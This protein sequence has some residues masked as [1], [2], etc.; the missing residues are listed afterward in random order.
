MKDHLV[1]CCFC[2]TLIGVLASKNVIDIPA[3]SDISTSSKVKFNGTIVRFNSYFRMYI[4]PW[5]LFCGMT[6]SYVMMTEM[7]TRSCIKTQLVMDMRIE[8]QVRLC[9]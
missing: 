1:L 9:S 5:V 8:F 2:F 4:T 6:R 3:R 7:R